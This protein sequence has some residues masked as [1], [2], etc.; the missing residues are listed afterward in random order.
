[1]KR[2]NTAKHYLAMVVVL[3][4][5]GCA[6]SGTSDPVPPDDGGKTAE[7]T[8]SGKMPGEAQPVQNMEGYQRA[9]R[10]GNALTHLAGIRIQMEEHYF[11]FG[12]FPAYLSDMD[13]YYP[14]VNIP[15]QIRQVRMVDEGHAVIALLEEEPGNWIGFH[16]EILESFP[17]RHWTCELNFELPPGTIPQCERVD[18]EYLPIQPSFD[19]TRAHSRSEQAICQSDRLM[20]SDQRLNRAYQLLRETATRDKQDGIRGEQI[21]WLGERD[22]VCEAE[23][24]RREYHVCLDRFI[25]ERTSSILSTAARLEADHQP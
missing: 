25:R 21:Q 4:A 13:I 18:A 14:E 24:S 3:F 23:S 19:C 9:A 22:T 8:Q 2:V 1:M 12:S 10:A 20:A 15:R 16:V 11:R 6:A 5:A 17:H 7:A